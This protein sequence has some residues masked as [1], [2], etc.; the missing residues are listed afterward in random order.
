[1]SDSIFDKKV[2]CTLVLVYMFDCMTFIYNGVYLY[3]SKINLSSTTGEK[4]P[5]QYTKLMNMHQ[6]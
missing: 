2:D 6:C 4:V 3:V 1:M 5:L